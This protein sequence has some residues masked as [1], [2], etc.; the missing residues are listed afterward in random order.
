MA[1]DL[2]NLA[3]G[4]IRFRPMVA[5]AFLV[6]MLPGTIAFAQPMAVSTTSAPRPAGSGAAGFSIDVRSAAARDHVAPSRGH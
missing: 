5:A 3:I 6:A 1:R 4:G 2:N